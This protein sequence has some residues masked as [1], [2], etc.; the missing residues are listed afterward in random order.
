MKKRIKSPKKENNTN[1]IDEN[2]IKIQKNNPS[3]SCKDENEICENVNSETENTESV[4]VRNH[5]ENN[6][7]S[8][9][10][11]NLFKKVIDDKKENQNSIISYN[12]NIKVNSSVE[13]N[14]GKKNQN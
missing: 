8:G 14:I 10:K 6:E 12:K 11:T 1:D 3:E 4:I 7:I 13:G 9:T 2:Q 5:N